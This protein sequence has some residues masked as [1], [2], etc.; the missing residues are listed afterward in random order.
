M[1]KRQNA[2]HDIKKMCYGLVKKKLVSCPRPF[3]F[4]SLPPVLFTIEK[5][6]LKKFF[7]VL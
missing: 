7:S 2:K 1:T 5:D 3:P 4:L 6:Y